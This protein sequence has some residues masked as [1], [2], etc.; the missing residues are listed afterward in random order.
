MERYKV[1]ADFYQALA[2]SLVNTNVDWK[3][4]YGEREKKGNAGVG[5]AELQGM[6][7]FTPTEECRPH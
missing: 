1:R 5:D 7:H 2:E 4:R 6:T 3:D